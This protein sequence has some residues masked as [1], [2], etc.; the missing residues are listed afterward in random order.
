M[1][2]LGLV[3][4]GP[5]WHVGVVVDT[6]QRSVRNDGIAPTIPLRLPDNSY[7]TVREVA[8]PYYVAAFVEVQADDPGRLDP[9][10]DALAKRLSLSTS[11]VV[12]FSIPARPGALDNTAA[13]IP[14]VP[15]DKLYRF[16]DPRWLAWQSF[17]SPSHGE[18]FLVTRDGTIGAQATLDNP[19]PVVDAALHQ[20]QLYEQEAWREMMEGPND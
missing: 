8:G 9:R 12:Q 16:Q 18:L 4:C 15:D 7:S 1:V 3:G 19:Q 5:A 14:P 13:T 11:P 10:V 2:L 6:P 20:N 17:G